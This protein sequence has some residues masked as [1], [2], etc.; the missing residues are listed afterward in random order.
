MPVQKS[1]KKSVNTNSTPVVENQQV[2]Q[3]EQVEPVVET[4]TTAPP[5]T[6]RGGKKASTTAPTTTS[7]AP[8]P[9]TT[10]TPTPAPAPVTA[11]APTPAVAPPK[12]RGGKKAV[13]E[14]VQPVTASEA[15]TAEAPTAEAP[16][17]EAEAVAAPKTQRGGKRKAASPKVQK[18]S[19]EKQSEANVETGSPDFDGRTRSFKVKLPNGENFSGRFTGLTPYQAANKALSK[20]FRTNDNS[21][22]TNNQVVFSI[23]ESTRG[24]KRNE[25]TYNGARVK[26]DEPIIYTIKSAN[27]EDRVITKQYKNLLT[28]VK[29]SASVSTSESAPASA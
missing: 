11:S 20:Y 12:Q 1:N 15:P 2:E 27:G 28:K 10:T 29:K 21:N 22:I 5:K 7:P 3:V 6:Q 8:A 16:T 26:L 19:E 14:S 18:N 23:R 24:S 4:V 9:V 17:A 13:S 25:Y